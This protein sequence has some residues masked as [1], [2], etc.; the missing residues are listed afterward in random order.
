[1]FE[2]RLEQQTPTSG[3]EAA[4]KA[5]VP[6]RSSS[7]SAVFVQSTQKNSGWGVCRGLLITAARCVESPEP[8]HILTDN[9]MLVRSTDRK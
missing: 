3:L 6:T 5:E 9:G 7:I 2:A 4:L 8:V 1:M